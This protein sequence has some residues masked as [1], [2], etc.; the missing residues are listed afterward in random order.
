[1]LS[2]YK[3]RMPV[4]CQSPVGVSRI[5]WKT[6]KLNITSLVRRSCWPLG[7]SVHHEIL[8]NRIEL[9]AVGSSRIQVF[10]VCQ[11]SFKNAI[12]LEL[13]LIATYVGLKSVA[14]GGMH[15][16]LHLPTWNHTAAILESHSLFFQSFLTNS[17]YVPNT[18]HNLT[19][20]V[21]GE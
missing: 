18:N 5:V 11:S 9:R 10:S 16:T 1:M 13:K 6:L 17:V 20:S 2:G 15:F 14:W 7:S 8:P 12:L 19:S 21:V 3:M 4:Q